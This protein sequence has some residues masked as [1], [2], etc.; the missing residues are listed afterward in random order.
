MNPFRQPASLTASTAVLALAAAAGLVAASP[1]SAADKVDRAQAARG[2]Y[3]V[4]TSACMDCHTPLKMGA[5]GPEPDMD[6]LLSGHPE[7][8]AMPPAPALP[9]GPWMVVSSATNTA[10]SGPW[11]VSFTAN[12]TPDDETG[13]GRWTARDFRQT[14]RTGRHMGKGR[15]LLPPMPVPVYN[16]FTDRDLDAI[17]AYL[18]TIPA[19]KNRVPEPWAPTPAT[20]AK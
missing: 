17:Y 7:G 9:A 6:R 3:L 11:G 14:I 15:A 5:N 4:A 1:A 20:A 10:W 13:L 2:K 18:R 8:L 19:V 16:H 12:L